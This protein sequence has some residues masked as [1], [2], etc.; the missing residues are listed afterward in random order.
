MTLPALFEPKQLD[1]IK[2]TVAKDCSP[3]EFDMFLHICRH[4]GLDPLKRDIFA[5]VFHASDAKKRQLTIVT[6]INGY[7]KIADRT[8]NY[9][10]DDRAPRI[11]YDESLK[12]PDNPLGIVRAEVTIYKRAHGEWF[13]VTADAYWSEYCPT[14]EGAVDKRKT[15]WV[16]MPRI[17]IAKVAEAQALRRA[18]PDD[19]ANLQEE[20][21]IDRRMVD[22]SPSEAA[23][24]A[25]QEQRLSLIGGKDAL[26]I[27]W[28]DGNALALVPVGQLGDKAL[29]FIEANK[30]EPLTVRAWAN[31]NMVT[32]REYWA[33]DKAGA[34]AVKKAVEAVAGSEAA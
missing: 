34:L 3:A 26:T 2:R 32:L 13:P 17:M 7:R 8:G 30:D 21:E 14:Y 18:F 12:G 6:S 1:L 20:A 11:E 27:D 24:A 28:C 25:Q 33:R 23:E 10:P 4:V 19:Y 22:I 16:K 15:G 31:R 5:F 9:R 29:A